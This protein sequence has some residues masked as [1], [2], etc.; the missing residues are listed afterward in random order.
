MAGKRI[1]VRLT[2]HQ[3]RR[4]EE[5]RGSFGADKKSASYVVQTAINAAYAEW[6][7]EKWKEK[8]PGEG[9]GSDLLKKIADDEQKH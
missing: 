4:L 9:I 3:A 2:P 5:L 6:K 1:C 7:N 8:T